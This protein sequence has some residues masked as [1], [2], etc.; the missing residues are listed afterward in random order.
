MKWKFEVNKKFYQEMTTTTDQT[1]K[2][3][4]TDVKQTQTQT[5]WFSWT[6]LKN[7][8]DGSWDLEQKIEGVKMQIDIGGNRVEY[9]ST[10]ETPGN[11]PL[12]DFFKALVFSKFTVTVDKDFKVTKITG[13]EDFIK[14]LVKANPQMEPLLNQILSEQAL[15]DMADPTFSVVTGKEVK[16]GDTWTKD[17][18]L[19][20][21]PI[22]SYKNTFKYT[23]EGKNSDA[24][25]E[26][27]KKLDKIKVETTLTY[28]PP[29]DPAAGNTL[30]FRIKSASL[31]SSNAGGTILF[32]N[33]KGRIDST[34][35][36]LDLNGELNIEISGQTTKV[37]LKQTQTTTVKTTDEEPAALKKKT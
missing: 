7:N 24:K 21:G 4:G 36:K 25:E 16:K 13:R 32:D 28:T 18:T 20:M 11:N 27:E 30:P 34:S 3:M 23:Y 10:K 31:T 12:A 29:K 33:E 37:D 22:G 5:F 1:M 35:M 2:V 6:P 26:A 19:D 8:S 15:K 9:D 17:T 14:N